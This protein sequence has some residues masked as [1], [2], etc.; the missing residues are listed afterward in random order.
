MQTPLYRTTILWGIV[1]GGISILY[2]LAFYTMG[3]DWF[4]H[5]GVQWS[6]LLIYFIG[7]L[8][9]C[10]ARGRQ[11]GGRPPFKEMMR[12]AFFTFAVISL[13]FYIFYYIFTNYIDPSLIE[14][15]KELTI[16]YLRTSSA[17]QNPEEIRQA[18]VRNY[19]VTIQN[20]LFGYAQSL[21]GGFGLSIFA[22]LLTRRN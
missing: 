14:K 5:A 2:L 11:I 8:A 13:C 12:T 7:M 16:N 21:I 6:V 19:A 4:L 1:A 18:E 3:A 10:V 20:T 15:Q 17:T 9:A 22:A